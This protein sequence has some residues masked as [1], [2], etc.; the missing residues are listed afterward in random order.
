MNPQPS[1]SSTRRDRRLE[2]A[3]VLQLLRDDR[4]RKWS[5]RELAAEL[6]ADAEPLER[7]LGALAADGVVSLAEGGVWAA[8]AA[9]RLDELGLVAI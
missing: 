6:Q 5:L 1:E 9:L 2:R 4:P 7:A 8:R 3:I